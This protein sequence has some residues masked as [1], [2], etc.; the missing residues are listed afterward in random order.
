MRLQTISWPILFVALT[1][2]AAAQQAPSPAAPRQQATPPRPPAPTGHRQPKMSDLPPAL[3]QKES[4][5]SSKPQAPRD[6]SPID[7]RLRICRGC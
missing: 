4:C 3:A 6:Q 7:E 5:Q 1:V 2:G